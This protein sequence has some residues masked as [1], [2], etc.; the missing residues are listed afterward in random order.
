MQLE[1]LKK[2]RIYQSVKQQKASLYEQMKARG[3]KQ[4]TVHIDEGIIARINDVAFRS[5]ATK[6]SVV[7][8]FLLLSLAEAE[9]YP[10]WIKNPN[11]FKE[12]ISKF[13]R[14]QLTFWIAG[15]IRERILRLSKNSCNTFTATM[16]K[17]LKKGLQLNEENY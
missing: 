12:N 4:V 17:L 6:R 8:S 2:K 13:G 15:D 7:E 14:K 3:E 9:N 5:D 11:G 1:N 16:Q 10:D